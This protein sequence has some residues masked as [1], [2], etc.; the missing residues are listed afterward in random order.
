[1]INFSNEVNKTHGSLNKHI[2]FINK[3]YSEFI[4]ATYKHLDQFSQS[5]IITEL[6]NNLTKENID[7]LDQLILVKK[8][9][10]QQEILFIVSL[11]KKY[12]LHNLDPILRDIYSKLNF[13]N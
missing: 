6:L 5:P 4:A 2:E 8:L 3:R 1:M 13:I 11:I 10:Y 7:K 12:E 9:M